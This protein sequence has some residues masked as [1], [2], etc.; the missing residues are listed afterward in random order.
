MRVTSTLRMRKAANIERGCFT[1]Q[2]RRHSSRKDSLMPQTL[3]Q[4]MP[5]LLVVPLLLDL[6]ARSLTN[7][8]F[9]VRS[10]RSYLNY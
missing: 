8:G 1:N 3:Y 10:Y 6:V 2:S 7:N 5:L 9:E 4:A